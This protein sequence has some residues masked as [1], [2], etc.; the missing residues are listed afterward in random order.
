T[1]AGTRIR[2]RI[3]VR[4]RI[5]PRI[6]IRIRPRIRAREGTGTRSRA[7]ERPR[8][9]TAFDAPA[10]LIVE[11]AGADFAA[12]IRVAAGAVAGALPAAATALSAAD[13]ALLDPVE[14]AVVV[15]AAS[16]LILAVLIT[17]VPL[18][19]CR[20]RHQQYQSAQ[21][22]PDHVLVLRVCLGAT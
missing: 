19:Q 15:V 1:G 11:L 7:R 18:R 21:E 13:A 12:Q 4:I 9:A 20:H 10:P 2:P 22:I 17:A 3:R 5:W 14:F 8:S 16:R 6:R